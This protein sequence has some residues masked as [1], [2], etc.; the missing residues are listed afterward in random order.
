MHSSHMP[1]AAPE[2]AGSG[3]QKSDLLGGS[4]F[5]NT[6][7]A[8]RNQ[9]PSGIPAARAINLRKF[10]K[11]TLRAFFDLE[12]PSG[13]IIRGCALHFRERWWVCFPGRPYKGQDGNETWANIIDSRDKETRDRF[14]KIALAAALEAYEGAA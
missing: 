8:S 14:Q 12:L 2:N 11:N 3:P 6:Q 7:P 5:S 9:S 1:R 4:R 10:E 13:L